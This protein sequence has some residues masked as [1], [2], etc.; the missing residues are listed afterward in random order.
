MNK[1]DKVIRFYEDAEGFYVDTEEMPLAVCI[2]KEDGDIFWQ[3]GAVFSVKN[4]RGLWVDETGNLFLDSAKKNYKLGLCS[5]IAEARIWTK[6]ISLWLLEKVIEEKKTL[7]EKLEEWEKLIIEK[8][9]SPTRLQNKK[10]IFQKLK[11]EE[12]KIQKKE[13]EI[14]NLIDKMVV[15]MAS[16]T[17]KSMQTNRAE[18]VKNMDNEGDKAIRIKRR[19]RTKKTRIKTPN[20]EAH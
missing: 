10:E 5:D 18:V 4:T 9:I 17:A 13:K 20:K 2:S 11:N 6:K 19:S 16:E 12:K 14:K 1:S 8:L 15:I 3:D 7:K